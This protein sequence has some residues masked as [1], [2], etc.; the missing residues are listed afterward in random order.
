MMDF[1]E[2]SWAIA[3]ALLIIGLAPFPWVF[4]FLWVRWMLGDPRA[5][6]VDQSLMK[7]K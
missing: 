7:S 1:Y 2:I 5:G 6:V 4:A 3:S